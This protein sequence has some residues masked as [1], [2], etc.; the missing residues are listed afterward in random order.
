MDLPI[1]NQRYRR[2]RLFFTVHSDQRLALTLTDPQPILAAAF[3]VVKRYLRP[4]CGQ[5]G[6]DGQPIAA[7][8]HPQQGFDD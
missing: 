6:I 2:L 8:F 3:A 1:V 4:V 7:A 5:P